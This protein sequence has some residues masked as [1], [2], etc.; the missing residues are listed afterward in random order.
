MPQAVNA[1]VN[2]QTF[3]QIDLVKKSILALY[4][5]DLEK[6][7]E[8]FTDRASLIFNTIPEQL[9]N[10]NS[11]FKFKPLL[12]IIVFFCSEFWQVQFLINITQ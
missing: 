4:E 1:F 5:E 12:L 8:E 9:S 6:H 11:L 10:H 2:G 3:K 7:D